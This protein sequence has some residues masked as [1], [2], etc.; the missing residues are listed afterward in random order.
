M[1]NLLVMLLMMVRHIATIIV[2]HCSNDIYA[3]AEKRN[4][5]PILTD[6]FGKKQK[7]T[8]PKPQISLT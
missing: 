6:L 3:S 4:M 2:Y 1:I 5:T 8:I 7:Q